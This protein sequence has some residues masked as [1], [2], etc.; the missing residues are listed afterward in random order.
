MKST[1]TSRS[2]P[3]SIQFGG[4]SQVSLDSGPSPECNLLAGMSQVSYCW[5]GGNWSVLTSFLKGLAGP[6]SPSGSLSPMGTVKTSHDLEK[7]VASQM[8]FFSSCSESY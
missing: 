5:V 8:L 1:G 4:H 7:N 2:I 6:K 3:G